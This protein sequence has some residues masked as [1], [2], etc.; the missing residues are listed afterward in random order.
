MG[1]LGW[2]SKVFTCFR[3]DRDQL[4]SPY[5]TFLNTLKDT[6][7]E[8]KDPIWSKKLKHNRVVLFILEIDKAELPR[9]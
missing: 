9:N 2:L 4:K 1:L 5:Y 8:K 3:K 6:F 7:E